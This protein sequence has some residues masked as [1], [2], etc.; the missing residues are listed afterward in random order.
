[1]TILERMGTVIKQ[2]RLSKGLS[3]EVLAQL[4]GIDRSYLSDIE[5]GQRNLTLSCIFKISQALNIPA[6]QLVYQAELN[7]NNS[8]AECN[9]N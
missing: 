5:Q 3:L 4:V 2:E 1:M 7:R 6:S 8:D 9:R